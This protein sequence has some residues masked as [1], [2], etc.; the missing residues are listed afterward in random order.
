MQR[1]NRSSVSLRHWISNLEPGSTEC[2][3]GSRPYQAAVGPNRLVGAAHGD[4]VDKF[5]GVT[6][7]RYRQIHAFEPTPGQYR[8][9]S[10]RAESDARIRTFQSAVGDSSV[11][12][13]FYENEGNPFGSNALVQ[14][15]R[16]IEVPCTRLDD[17][18]ERC[19]IIKMD[20]EGAECRVIRGAAR[21]IRESR[22][23]MAITCYHY[24]QDMHEIL[25]LVAETHRYRH[26]ALR[27]YGPS[28]YDSVLL[29]S[30][31]QSFE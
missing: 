23:D 31:R 14:N 16:R 3:S 30:D 24:P 5:H 8:A 1:S 19:T 13:T 27:H 12:I 25:E 7:G 26:I 15:G 9:L 4:T 17:V 22:P 11:P 21:L 10:P 2:A 6:A 29:F 28:L 20:V 18:V